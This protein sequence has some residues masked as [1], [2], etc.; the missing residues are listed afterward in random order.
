[1]DGEHK[2]DLYENSDAYMSTII[3]VIYYSLFSFLFLIDCCCGPLCKCTEDCGGK[4]CPCICQ[5]CPGKG[6][7]QCVCGDKCKCDKECCAGC[8]AK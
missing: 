8:R 4:C 3:N 6:K 2:G 5:G 7:G 1:M